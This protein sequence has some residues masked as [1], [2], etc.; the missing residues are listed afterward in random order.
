MTTAAKVEFGRFDEA[1][2]A[3]A[4]V[5]KNFWKSSL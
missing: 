3:V 1:E 4:K 2:G 5:E